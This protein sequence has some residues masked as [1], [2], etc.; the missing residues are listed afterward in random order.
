MTKKITFLALKS[1]YPR[2]QG[3][4]LYLFESNYLT[5][6][7]LWLRSFFYNSVS[8]NSNNKRYDTEKRTLDLELED[9][10]L[11]SLVVTRHKTLIKTWNLSASVSSAY[12]I[13]WIF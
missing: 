1:Q 2:K 5:S 12:N 6:L 8:N 10:S 4:R 11:S 9:L 7:N 3:N 13:V